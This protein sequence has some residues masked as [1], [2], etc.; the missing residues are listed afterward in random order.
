MIL[1]LYEPIFIYLLFQE[2]KTYKF[3]IVALLGSRC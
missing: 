1:D 3:A 2:T